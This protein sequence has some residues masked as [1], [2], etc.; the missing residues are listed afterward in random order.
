[1]RKAPNPGPV[2]DG[3]QC[4][5]G[6]GIFKSG[7]CREE[8][9]AGVQGR[10]NAITKLPI[11]VSNSPVRQLESCPHSPVTNSTPEQAGQSFLGTTGDAAVWDRTNRVTYSG[12][13]SAITSQ[14]KGA[15]E[16]RK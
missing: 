3:Q 11:Y 14:D 10:G 4:K 7:F 12:E 2:Q 15:W 6:A 5:P 16:I 8:S 13:V 9:G 1:M